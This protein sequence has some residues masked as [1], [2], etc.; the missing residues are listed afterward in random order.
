[1]GS[2]KVVLRVKYFFNQAKSKEER[3]NLHSTVR[4][5]DNKG[6]IS[7]NQHKERRKDKMKN[8]GIEMLYNQQSKREK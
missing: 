4:I 1:M 7:S 5:I 6:R 2:L 3:R 8:F